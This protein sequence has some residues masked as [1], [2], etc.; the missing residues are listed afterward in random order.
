M[1]KY[2]LVTPAPV[3]YS[4]SNPRSAITRADSALK[5]PGTSRPLRALTLSR[6]I[7]LVV[8]E[9]MVIQCPLPGMFQRCECPAYCNA[10]AMPRHLQCCNARKEDVSSLAPEKSRTYH[11]TPLCKWRFQITGNGHAMLHLKH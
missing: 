11:N 6:R 1:P 7:C 9:L 2:M 3:T 4:A 10:R 5:A 8:L